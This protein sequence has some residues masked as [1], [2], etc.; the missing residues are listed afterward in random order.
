MDDI[1]E[2][3]YAEMLLHLSSAASDDH[4]GAETID[5]V[6]IR[7]LFV[8]NLADRTTFK[9]L[10]TSF[11][12]YGNV[13]SCFLRRN[14]GKRNYAFVTFS[15]VTEAIKARLDGG[16]KQIRLHNR[17]L[18]VMPADSWHQP[19]SIE[20][21]L[22]TM[23]KESNKSSEK[24]VN[25]QCTQEYLQND[26]NRVSIHIL[27]DDCLRH[28]FLFLPIL[29]RVRIERVCRRW[30]ILSQDSW[31]MMKTLDLSPLTW[32]SMGNKTISTAILR[33]ILLKSGRFLTRVNLSEPI[34]NLSQSTLTIVGKLCPNLESVDVTGLT[35]CASGIQML[36]KNCRNI[37][38]FNLGPSSYSCDNELKELF[39]LNQNLE[40]LAITRNGVLGKCL[41][42]LPAQT[43]H[44]VILEGCDY[45]QDSCVSTALKKL[46]NLR[47]L[48]IDNC[49]GVAKHTFETISK[50]CRNLRVL[51]LSGDFPSM[52]TADMLYLTHLANLQV[53]RIT[54]NPKILDEF[55]ASLVYQC[56]QL[57]CIDITGCI[58]VTDTGLAAIA[59]LAKLEK[60]T[61]NNLDCVTDDG[62]QNMCNLREMHCQ[63]CPQIKDHGMS[64][65]IKSSPQLQ[66][67]DL[68][69][70]GN[71]T[72][73]TLKTAKDACNDRSNNTVL[74]MIIGGTSISPELDGETTQQSSPLLQIVNVDLS[75]T[76]SDY[77]HDID[78]E[79][80]IDDTHEA[81]LID[82]VDFW[83]SDFE[84]YTDS[85][86]SNFSGSNGWDS[87]SSNF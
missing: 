33:K 15:K 85:Y 60:L 10:H 27:N 23:G 81:N 44:T 17:D 31:H 66:L 48:T 75:T 41:L 30:R 22:Y 21:K 38:K 39:K 25:E 55:L 45:V 76:L 1:I 62:L 19:D 69:G 50:H 64:M 47:H 7:K 67:L 6:P 87:D 70:C 82:S 74:K 2:F 79:Y 14:H 68:S 63:R 42:W 8:S 71:I 13:E 80:D 77:M 11:S 26:T 78:D 9:D 18:R 83:S 3:N 49:I 54:D 46:E 20:H 56:Q 28:I 51:E 53:L 34:H 24:K 52:Q 86:G 84:D 40:H 4:L 73:A 36:A 61:I 43:V 5:G 59:T 29:D 72:H 35:V 12:K 65:L 57:T 32:G 37:T 58:G 16:R